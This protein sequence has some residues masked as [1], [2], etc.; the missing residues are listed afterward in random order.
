MTFVCPA[1]REHEPPQSLSR[2]GTALTCVRCNAR[3]P[4]G[5]AP[6]IAHPLPPF[7]KALSD[8]LVSVDLGL[9]REAVPFLP[10][11]APLARRLQRVS[12]AA[13]AHYG[14]S[15][16]KPE[17]AAW[18]SLLPVLADVAKGR[19]LELG[20]G[21]GRI[22]LELA[23]A[24]REVVALDTDP[25][26]LSLGVDIQRHGRARTLVRSIGTAYSQVEINAPDLKGRAVTFAL[27][28]ALNPP[29]PAESFD[30]VVALN[31][32]D[33]VR[34]PSTL[35]G[36]IDALLRPGGT[37]VMSTPYAWDS[38]LVD[39]GERIGGAPG[40]PFG[41]D[42]ERE[43]R[44]V[45]TAGDPFPWKFEILREIPKLSWT[46]VRDDRCR[47]QYDLHVVVARKPR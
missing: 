44:R 14:D 42:P 9:A 3:F 20:C 35:L 12:V 19:V 25:A 17:P 6:V 43:L 1:C 27:A 28:D 7:L 46:L 26:V 30:A 22:A 45:L 8:D 31:L 15:F 41:D 37:L 11:D 40:R 38:A 36:Q 33:N 34:V 2:D 32:L 10:D 24:G 13:R 39:D 16:E 29:L 21:A 18:Q 23:A 47:F 4:I 5:V